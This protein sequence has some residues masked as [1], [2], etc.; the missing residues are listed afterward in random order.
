MTSGAPERRKT[1]QLSVG[2][3]KIGGDAPVSIQSM[4]NTDTR[5]VQATI[6]QIQRLEAAGCE[7]VR[8]A[9]PDEDAAKALKE[10]KAEVNLPLIA[11]IHFH[12]TLALMALESGVDGLRLNPGNIGARW[13]VEEVVKAASE[14]C[15]PIRIGVNSGSVEK[16]VLEKHGGPTPAAL[17]E[18]ALGHVRILEDLDYDRIKVSL[19]GSQVM[20]TVAAYKLMSAERDYPLHIGITE[21]GTVF[22]GGVKSGVGIGILLYEG[23]GDTLRVSLTGD[24][25][26]EVEVAWWILGAL[27][28][29]RRGVEVISCPTCAR[30]RLPIETLALEVEKALA[31]LDAP[32]TVAV[33]GCEVNGPGEAREADVGVASGKGYGL[34]FKRGEVVGKVPENE[35][36]AAVVKMAREV[37]KEKLEKK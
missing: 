18:S 21:A 17:V 28:I 5:D 12:H 23:L 34:L 6:R 27:G 4:T 30:T 16:E 7:I 11:D 2:K 31:D 10:I 13:K 15:I 35:V 24:P 33:M 14:R 37:A 36:V 1:R 32:V 26:R 19:K 25:V 20:Q 22:R 8:L 9:V 29:R 3:V